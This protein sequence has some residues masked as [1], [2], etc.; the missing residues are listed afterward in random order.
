MAT[1]DV[2]MTFGEYL[3]RTHGWILMNRPHSGTWARTQPDPDPRLNGLITFADTAAA[4]GIPTDTTLADI[5][6]GVMR[7]GQY[8]GRTF[9]WITLHCVHYTNWMRQLVPQCSTEFFRLI[10]YAEHDGTAAAEAIWAPLRAAHVAWMR[11]RENRRVAAAAAAG[12]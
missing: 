5:N 10:Q 3:G 1:A 8:R 7:I 2:V 6:N 12:N 11:E 9:A 4:Q